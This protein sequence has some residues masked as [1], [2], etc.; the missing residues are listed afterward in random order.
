MIGGT[1]WPAAA[2]R[3]KAAHLLDRVGLGQRLT[4]R[5]GEL[6]GGECQRVAVVRALMMDPDLVFADEPSGNLDAQASQ[7]LHDIIVDLAHSERQT[8]MVMTHDQELAAKFDRSGYLEG[9][10]LKL[11]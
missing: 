2:A 6:S 3:D 7:R 8:F 9:G 5:P 4:H 10:L 11:N 1:T